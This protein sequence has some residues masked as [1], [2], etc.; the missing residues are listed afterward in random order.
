MN[1]T[2]RDILSRVA[3]LVTTLEQLS[4]KEALANPTAQFVEEY[5][6]TRMM[7]LELN[8]T[9]TDAAPP[10]VLD[11]CRYVELHVYSKQLQKLFIRIEC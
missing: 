11:D 9:F 3:G 7:F 4:T 2:N 8:Q 6:R 1:I 5:N 10:E